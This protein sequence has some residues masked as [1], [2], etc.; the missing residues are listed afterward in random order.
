MTFQAKRENYL[1]IGDIYPGWTISDYKQGNGGSHEVRN[2]V[3]HYH[4]ACAGPFCQ[5]HLRIWQAKAR[6]E[7]AKRRKE[8]KA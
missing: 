4:N 3:A 1:C 6:A 8:G 2:R 7:H 5:K